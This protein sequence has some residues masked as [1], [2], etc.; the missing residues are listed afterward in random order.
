MSDWHASRTVPES[1]ADAARVPLKKHIQPLPLVSDSWVINCDGSAFP[2]P[3]TM[4][5]GASLVAPDGTQHQL[6][7]TASSKGCNNEAEARAMLL[8]LQHARLL[9]ARNVRIHSDSRVVVDQLSGLDSRKI[10]R[11]EELFENIRVMLASFDDAS[12]VWIPGHR[13]T[14][15]DALA[16]AAAGL[17]PR[18]PVIKVR[19]KR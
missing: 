6:S 3:R 17:H 18:L 7:I 10:D 8:A 4:G 9:G 5:L 16:R 2:N 1:D 19:R 14:E 15:A 13:N 11:L 12:V